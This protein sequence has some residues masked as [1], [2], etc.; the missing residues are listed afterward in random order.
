[1]AER[2]RVATKLVNAEHGTVTF[3]AVADGKTFVAELSKLPQ[4]MIHRL[5]LHGIAQKLGDTYADGDNPIAGVTAAFQSLLSGEWSQRG[6]AG[7]RDSIFL[8]ALAIVHP[9][10]S[11]LYR[12]DRDKAI[13]NVRELL[14][15]THT[16]EARK[17]GIDV[18]NEEAFEKFCS[19]FDKDLRAKPA[20]KAEMKRITAERAM[21]ESAKAAEAAKSAAPGKLF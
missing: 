1:M 12:T 2:K 18:G 20:V 4:P 8:E 21:A 15:K 16:A 13:A 14:D 11:D 17:G 19:D 9:K 10:T 7:P 6:E 5:A 3:K